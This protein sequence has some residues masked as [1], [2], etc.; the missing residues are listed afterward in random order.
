MHGTLRFS[1]F[2]LTCCTEYIC[3]KIFI[4]KELSTQPPRILFT[5]NIQSG[6]SCEYIISV[7]SFKKLQVIARAIVALWLLIIYFSPHKRTSVVLK[8]SDKVLLFFFHTLGPIKKQ[9]HCLPLQRSVKFK[10][11]THAKENFA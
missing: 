4:F 8:P 6:R 5:D 3:V 2:Y 7:Y 11:S 1:C 10:A 9:Q